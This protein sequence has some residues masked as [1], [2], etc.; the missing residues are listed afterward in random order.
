MESESNDI[1]LIRL[2]G[3][4]DMY[5]LKMDNLQKAFDQFSESMNGVNKSRADVLDK[6]SDRISRLE[7]FES[8]L[9]GI[10]VVIIFLTSLI[11]AGVI[12]LIK[13]AK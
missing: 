13:S 9:I 4:I 1:K 11:T 5:N 7:R 8:K 3:K 12:G 2:E 10:G 6:I